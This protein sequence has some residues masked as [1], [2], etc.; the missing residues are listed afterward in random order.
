MSH[1]STAAA[2]NNLA[3]VYKAMAEQGIPL[4]APREFEGS[5]NDNPPPG[6]S[7]ADRMTHLDNA[8]ELLQEVLESRK[9]RMG[10]DHPDVAV[11]MHQ[12]AG[13]FRM[14]GQWDKAERLLL[15]AVANLEE[16]KNVGGE[17]PTFATALNNLALFYKTKVENERNNGDISQLDLV[18]GK[19][20]LESAQAMYEH[21]L[22]VKFMACF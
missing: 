13:V 17:H 20:D 4:K 22:K 1:A 16:H 8:R 18:R 7:A 11:T 14:I 19:E 9:S 15:T 6:I 3:L 21:S 10:E 5:E 2:A 12:L